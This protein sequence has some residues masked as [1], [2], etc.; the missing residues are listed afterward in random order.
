M[1]LDLKAG[2]Q[3]LLCLAQYLGKF[4]PRLSDMTRLLRELTQQNED[5]RWEEEHTKAL[6]QLKGAITKTSILRYFNAK[7]KVQSSV[8]RRS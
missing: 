7:D 1:C 4:Q 2:V 8:M 5:W 6:K 3:R